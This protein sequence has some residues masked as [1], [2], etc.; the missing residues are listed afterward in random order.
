MEFELENPLPSCQCCNQDDH[1]LHSCL[2][3]VES[4]HMPSLSYSHSLKSSA[5][6]FRQEAVS[7]I[8]Q[9]SSRFDPF[10]SYLAVN[11]L[12]RFL[13]AKG[14][15]QEKP[16]VIKLLAVSCI[17]LAV[18]MMNR[19]TTDLSLND[20]QENVNNGGL[21]F[22][23][24]TIQRM[25]TLIL[26]ALQW[27]MRSVTPFSF[28]HFFTHYFSKLKDPPLKQA[29]RTRAVEIIFKAQNE[30]KLVGFK[31]SVIAASGL[32]TSCH[33]LFPLQFSCFKDSIL[34]CSYVN[35]VMEGTVFLFG[36]R[37]NFFYSHMLCFVY[38]CLLYLLRAQFVSEFQ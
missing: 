25:E 26:G 12:D 5:F 20:I 9:A 3:L 10:L 4:E 16:W 24:Q 32:L 2:F 22:D 38:N 7:S 15:P 28:I 27:R 14:F 31:P 17:S 33:E 36:L 23:T 8:L 19:T 37:L 30:V 21:I 11:Y 13:S 18:K 1:H 34:S 29:L 35:K 6:S